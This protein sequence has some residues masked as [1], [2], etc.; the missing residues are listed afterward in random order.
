MKTISVVIP[1]YNTA[2]YIDRVLT[3]LENQTVG[4]DSLEIICVDDCSDDNTLE[5]L[6]QWEN[7]YPESLMIVAL[8]QHTRQGHARN[9]GLQYASCEFIAF[10]DSDDWVEKNY[11]EKMYDIA[12]SGNYDLVQCEYIRDASQALSYNETSASYSDLADGESILINTIE[13]RKKVFRRKV[14]TNTPPLKLIKKDL[15]T[16]NNIVFSEG[17]AYEDS[18]WGILLNM[19]VKRAYLLHAPLYHYYI[20]DKSTVLTTDQLY[21][22]DLL[23][24]QILI[25]NELESRGLMDTYRDEIELEHVYSCALIFWKMILHRYSTPQYSLYRLLCAVIRDHIPNILSN[26]YISTLAES[27]MI[28]LKSC[29]YPLSEAEFEAFAR[30]AKQIP[31]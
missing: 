1:F 4:I 12:T 25:W 24:N 30:D 26:P 15:L 22:I 20:N 13:D 18:Y 5:I 28:L 19:Y 8:D 10:I 31:L 29:I 11:F 14:I 2:K 3:S 21:H 27:H 6:N 9:I 23:T 16:G 7:K 17:L